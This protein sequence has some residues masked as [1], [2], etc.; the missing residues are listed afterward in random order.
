MEIPPALPV[1]SSSQRLQVL[2]Y[3]CSPSFIHKENSVSR[4][5][6]FLNPEQSWGSCSS[7]S[8]PRTHWGD[9]PPPPG[10][11]PG[12]ET[13]QVRP[14]VT[15][16]LAA[17]DSEGLSPLLSL[18]CGFRPLREDLKEET[19][20]SQG[21]CAMKLQLHTA[22][23]GPSSHLHR[24]PGDPLDLRPPRRVG[25]RRH[26]PPESSSRYRRQISSCPC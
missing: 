12:Q 22:Q 15:C 19:G 16:D 26:L 13:W 4:K 9:A 8:F 3:Q 23:S 24:R 1:F 25:R 6:H 14:K 18:S 2:K 11:R 5:S 17:G 20:L 21:I 10:V 7:F